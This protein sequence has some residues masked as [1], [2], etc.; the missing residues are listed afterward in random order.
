LVIWWAIWEKFS[1]H[2]WRGKRRVI[3]ILPVE[4]RRVIGIPL[5]NNLVKI[6]VKV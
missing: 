2:N 6:V 4:I 3:A 1:P 5:E